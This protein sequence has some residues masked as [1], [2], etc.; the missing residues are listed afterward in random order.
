MF[1]DASGPPTW[2]ATAGRRG[3]VGARAALN[4]AM[5][6]CRYTSFMETDGGPLRFRT[7]RA[8]LVHH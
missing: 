5:V 6:G 2:F 7:P 4:D 3:A 1:D 8:E